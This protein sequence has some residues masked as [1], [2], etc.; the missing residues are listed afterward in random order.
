MK[1][2]ISLLLALVMCLSLCACGGGESA[3]SP[4]EK[5]AKYDELFTYLETNDYDSANAY[6]QDFFGV[7]EPAPTETEPVVMDDRNDAANEVAEPAPTETEPMKTV[8]TLTA[9]QQMIA[10]AVRSQI[11]SEQF[12]QWQKLAED[13]SG[14][15][16]KAPEVS[17]VWHYEI[18]DFDEKKMDCYLVNISADVAYWINE[19]AGQGSMDSQFQ[20]FISSDGKTVVDS[21]TTDAG[22]VM[23]DTATDEGRI[24]YLLWMFG[25]MMNSDFEGFLRNDSETVTKWTAEEIAVVNG[26]I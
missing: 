16:P 9:E 13:F 2:T 12:T 17:A 21:I 22:N 3:E 15:D 14:S 11:Q 1:K 23:H 19:E 4:Y 5:Y 18:A 24:T 25:V 6:I 20:L 8:S 26:N 10:D 7:T